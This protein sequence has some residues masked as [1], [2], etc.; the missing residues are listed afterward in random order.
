MLQLHQSVFASGKGLIRTL[1]DILFL[2]FYTAQQKERE[3]LDKWKYYVTEELLN[4]TDVSLV[5]ALW[6]F[7]I[8]QGM[9]YEKKN[10]SGWSNICVTWK[11]D[12]Q[13]TENRSLCVSK[14]RPVT[15]TNKPGKPVPHTNKTRKPVP[16]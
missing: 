4:M 2:Y 6:C 9:G 8:G 5:I 12:W 10:K 11:R 14:P 15:H 13:M 16:H 7:Q 3:K 1:N